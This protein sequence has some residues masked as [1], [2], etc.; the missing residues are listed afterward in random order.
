MIMGWQKRHDPEIVEVLEAFEC[1]SVFLLLGLAHLL[2]Q[3]IS[4]FLKMLHRLQAFPA[5]MQ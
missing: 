2:H 3:L 4:V 5:T 1:S